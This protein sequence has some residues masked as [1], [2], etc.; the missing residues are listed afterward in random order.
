MSTSRSSDWIR[1][2]FALGGAVALAGSVSGCTAPPRNPDDLCSIF[3]QRHAWYRATGAAQRR[4]GID[5]AIQMAVIFQE[6][7][8]RAGARPPRTKLLGF[9]PWQ[10]RSSAYGYAQ[11]V[12][13]TWDVYRRS[14]SRPRAQRNRFPDATDFIGW[15]M[16]RIAERAKIE[17]SSVRALYL[18][19]HEGAGGYQRGTHL[20]KQWLL[21]AS[22]LVEKRVARY[23]AQLEHCRERLERHR[24]WWPF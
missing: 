5:Q 12:D 4:W 10:R 11:A 15:Y 17:K 22:S 3:S 8:F 23:R 21:D 24:W 14:A 7:S 13:S 19:Y 2:V 20:K 1:L 6:S 16:N 18:A 9:I